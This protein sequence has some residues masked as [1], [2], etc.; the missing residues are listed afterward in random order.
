MLLTIAFVLLVLWFLGMVTAHTLGSALHALLVIA[1]IMLLV[2]VIQGDLTRQR[3]PSRSSR[4]GR[5]RPDLPPEAFGVTQL[6]W[7]AAH[8]LD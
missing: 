1:I 3:R 2:R 7:S 4:V 8:H 6:G 5:F